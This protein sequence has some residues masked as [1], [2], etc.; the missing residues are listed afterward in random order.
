LTGLSLAALAMGTMAR[1]QDNA[2]P[3]AGAPPATDAKEVAP[4]GLAPAAS[5]ATPHNYL[6]PTGA[7]N[8][9]WVY[10]SSD[11]KLQQ[12]G[13]QLSRESEEFVSRY[14]EASDDEQRQKIKAQLA[15]LV[16]KQFNLQQQIREDEVAQIEAR[17]KKLRAL[18]EKRKA[19]QQ[20]IIE[21]RLDQLLREAEGLGWTPPAE[22]DQQIRFI[23]S[24]TLYSGA[25]AAPPVA[26]PAPPRR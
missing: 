3:V 26:V 14:S 7:G 8:R 4:I 18:I 15:E 1:G 16:A 6:V 21:N 24:N 23:R 19:A 20:S 9:V 22:R 11:G 10:E 13:A 5:N 2:A 12:A 17:V 25:G